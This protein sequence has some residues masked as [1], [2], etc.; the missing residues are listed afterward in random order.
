MHS[1]I[2]AVGPSR[3]AGTVLS[4]CLKVSGRAPNALAAPRFMADMRALSIEPGIEHWFDSGAMRTFPRMACKP[5][6]PDIKTKPECRILLHG[7][8]A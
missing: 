6:V 5:I 2:R 7:G 1:S 4:F 8:R 3:L